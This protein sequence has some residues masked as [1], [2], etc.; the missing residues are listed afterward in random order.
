MTVAILLMPRSTAAA[1]NFI[2]KKGTLNFDVAFQNNQRKEFGDVQNPNDKALFFDL[3][4]ITYNTRYN[5]NAQNGWETSFGVSG[6]QQK[7][8]NRGVEFLIPQY[9][10]FDGGGF[11]LTQKTFGKKLTLAGGLR[12]DN[13]NLQT[14][15]L[16]LD[17]LAT[18]TLV[19]NSSTTAKFKAQNK[20][21]SGVSGSLGASYQI[22]NISTL[23]FNVSRGFRAPNIA[24]LASNGRHEGTFRYEYG[25]INLQSEISHQI[26]LAYLLNSDHVSLQVSPFV[27]S[28]QN[29]IYVQ[30]LT[31]ANGNDSIPEP[32]DP[33]PAYRFTQGAATLLGGELY[34]D[35]HP[36]P[37]DWLHFENSFSAVQAT[38]SRA[39]DSTRYLPN[40][41]AAHYRG[42]IKAQFKTVGQYL[43]NAY[44]KFGV[45]YFFRQNDILS[46]DRTETATPDYTLLNFGMGASVQAFGK[47]DGMNIY[48]NAENLTDVAYQNHLSRLKYAPLNAATGRNGVFNMGRNIS[49]KLIFNW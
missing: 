33:A 40:T 47:K 20:N 38:Q 31:T 8:V 29:F 44:A 3:N 34:I 25:D 10:L 49:V 48:I 30:K 4:T 26:D 17:S 5:L 12:F 35:V 24:E 37:F 13:R 46:A 45:D 11:A 18:P 2:L 22:N 27:N 19:E 16:I 21:Y 7:N 14:E 41:P 42:E 9:N 1:A 32:S 39:T 36:H 28:I 15:Q 6:M 43:S 23:K